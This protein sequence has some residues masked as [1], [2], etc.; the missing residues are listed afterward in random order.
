MSDPASP[1]A[2][3]PESRSALIL[4]LNTVTNDSRIW[5]EARTLR[6]L[7]FDVT[8][9]GVV[10]ADET[11][12]EL[13]LNGFRVIRLAPVETLRRIRRRRRARRLPAGS[14]GGSV[15]AAAEPQRPSIRSAAV[16]LLRRLAITSA[17]YLQGA[18]LV[19]RTSP[20]L[21]H[22]NDYNTMW[23]GIVAKLLRRSRL[24]YDAHELWPDQGR[25][26]WRPWQIACEW[27]FLRA[28]DATVAANPGIADTLARR[29]RVPTPVVVRNVPERM[30][31]R[32][33][34]PEGLR[35]G[36]AP[37]AMY[38]GG[39]APERGI[40]EM[41]RA[42]A[43]VPDLRLRFMG[44]G[45]ADYRAALDRIAAEA[46]VTDRIEHRP[47]VEPAAVAETIA[48]ADLGVVLTQATCLNNVQSLPNKLFEYTVAGLPVIASDLPVIA[49]IVRGEDIGEVVDP[50]DVEAIAAAM[51]RLVEPARNAD[52]RERVRD[53]SER[54]NW[55]TEKPLLE[56]VYASVS[57]DSR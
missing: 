46:G 37:L 17:Y 49:A 6:A 28:A 9:A 14:N 55:Q 10:S 36:A 54:V 35:A 29:Y 26:E 30:A 19:R 50:A 53:F 39:L 48:G 7:G 8:I 34:P 12:T 22:A 44:Y 45:S 23:I 3:R 52:V 27:L 41:I 20:E 25:S 43:L 2:R 11:E 33:A 1:A 32:P 40:E 24:V 57:R 4:V 13:H 5:R 18:A 51:R 16:A 47:P 38:V 15:A 42:L 21:V 56:G 31:Q